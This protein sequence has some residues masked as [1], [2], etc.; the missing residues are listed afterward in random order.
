MLPTLAYILKDFSH[1]SPAYDLCL[2]NI[3]PVTTLPILPATHPEH[4]STSCKR[5]TDQP[6]TLSY[7]QEV[8]KAEIF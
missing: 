4:S 2:T 8:L 6:S 5:Q 3:I 1:I 7:A